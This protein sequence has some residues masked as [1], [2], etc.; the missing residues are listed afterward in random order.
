MRC[1]YW[2]SSPEGVAPSRRGS[3]APGNRSLHFRPDGAERTGDSRRAYMSTDLIR[4]DLLVQDALRGVMRKVLAD[5]ALAGRLPGDHHFTI[6]FRTKAPGVKI[7]KRLAEQWPKEMT[8]ILQH[9]YSN[10][11]VDERGF[12]VGLSFRSIPEQLYVPFEA[13]TVFSDPS[14]D[15]GLKWE[16][17]ELAG[18]PRRGAELSFRR[19][20]S[21]A[22]SRPRRDPARA[23]PA[24]RSGR[25]R[26]PSR[27]RRAAARP[28][29]SSPST[30]SARRPDSSWARSSICDAPA[31]S[32]TSAPKRRRPTPI[33]S[34]SAA[35]KP[36]ASSAKRAPVSSEKSST[37]IGWK[38]RRPNLGRSEAS[39]K[40]ARSAIRCALLTAS[41][42][43]RSPQ[44]NSHCLS[45]KPELSVFPI[46]FIERQMAGGGLGQLALLQP[47]EEGPQHIL[48]ILR[49]V[50]AAMAVRDALG[51]IGEQQDQRLEQRGIDDVRLRRH[52]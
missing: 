32:G 8:I 40:A 44:A 25:T 28:P 9:Q 23:P 24:A 6:S 36:S 4:Y 52:G 43:A 45:E 13:V 1:W 15:F 46:I 34:P 12:S 22:A 30:L 16:V 47:A 5:A 2:V 19:G 14:V 26:P 31:R 7:S 10:L 37:R 29:R 33:A 49:R 42:R 39:P 21:R 11:V 51:D 17:D 48:E 27:R 38:I 35:R 50:A 3:E 18:R 20:R 41:L